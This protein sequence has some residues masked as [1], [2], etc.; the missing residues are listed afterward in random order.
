LK[1]TYIAQVDAFTA[2]PFRGNP[3][4]VCILSDEAPESWMQ[5]VATEMNLSE[6]AFLRM[7]DEGHLIRYF[8]PTCEVPLCGHA[9]LASAHVLWEDDFVDVDSP[10]SLRAKGGD[11]KARR[12]QDWICL[13]FPA[14]PMEEAELPAGLAEAL[15]ATPRTASASPKLGYLLEMDS[16]ATVKELQPDFRLLSKGEYWGVIVTAACESGPYDFVSRFFAPA[17]GIDEDP[18]TGVAHCSL[19]P[20]W[21]AKLGKTDLTGLQVSQ[22]RGV[23]KVNVRGERVELL[24]QAVTVMRAHLVV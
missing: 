1:K 2:E 20:Y 18:V 24:G 22:R 3:A 6:T 21:A 15:G 16:E 23:V 19:G 10:I 12:E 8:T 5:S 7:R 13:N 9:T 14:I 17:V 4:A 11:L